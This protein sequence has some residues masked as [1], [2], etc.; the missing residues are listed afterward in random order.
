M[1][2]Y[3]NLVENQGTD[4][5]IVSRSMRS[6]VETILV[7]FLVGN[8]REMGIDDANSRIDGTNYRNESRF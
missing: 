7:R 2:R 6:I 4:L 5:V 3:R 8:L 1:K